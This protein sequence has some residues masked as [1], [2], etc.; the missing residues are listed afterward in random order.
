MMKSENSKS[1]RSTLANRRSD[2][3]HHQWPLWFAGLYKHAAER[4]KWLN[5]GPFK[6]FKATSRSCCASDTQISSPSHSQL[7]TSANEQCKTK[8]VW[9]W[10]TTRRWVNVSTHKCF[11]DVFRV[12]LFCLKSTP[13]RKILITHIVHIKMLKLEFWVH[14][15]CAQ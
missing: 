7:F 9:S 12:F 3:V 1:P 13:S 4:M 6:A 5:E 14:F 8:P 10:R 2:T 15:Q 11:Q